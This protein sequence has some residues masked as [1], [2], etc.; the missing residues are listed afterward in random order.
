MSTNELEK[1]IDACIDL[2]FNDFDHA[3]I[4]GHYTE[5][6]RFGR[7]I[8]RRPDLKYKIQITTKCGIRLETPNRPSHQIKSY[9]STADHLIWSAENSLTQLGVDCLDI[10]LIHRPDV[11]MNPHEIAEAFEKLRSAG[12]VKTFGVSNF[13]PCLLYTSPSPRDRQKSRMPS[14]A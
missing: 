11:L 2:G 4:Y 6:E 12:K 8:K 9:D 7:V 10:M 3:D 5:E 14:S 1:F 13:T